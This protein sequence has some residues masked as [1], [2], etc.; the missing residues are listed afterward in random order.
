MENLKLF[1]KK[2][3]GGAIMSDTLR[4]WKDATEDIRGDF[5]DL[6]RVIRGDPL[7]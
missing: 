2:V 6:R 7:A 1:D 3:I 5:E 4:R